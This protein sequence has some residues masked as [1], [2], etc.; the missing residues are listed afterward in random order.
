MSVRSDLAL[1]KELNSSPK[2]IELAKR[3]VAANISKKV[4]LPMNNSRICVAG[5]LDLEADLTHQTKPARCQQAP[6]THL[7]GKHC[8][9][10]S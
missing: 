4:V 3:F 8:Q 6:S 10:I 1:R 5:H 9:C 2:G 7:V